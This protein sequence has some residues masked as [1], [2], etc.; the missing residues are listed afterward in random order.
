MKRVLLLVVTSAAALAAGS[1][2][3]AQTLPAMDSV[4]LASDV[5][6]GDEGRVDE[7]G[8]VEERPALSPRA[9]AQM[10]LSQGFS[11]LSP[12]IRRG[13]AYV[14]AVI[15]PNGDDGRVTVDASS[16]RIVR[17]RPIYG[18]GAMVLPDDVRGAFAR[19]DFTPPRN[20]PYV[21]PR[22]APKAASNGAV[23]NGAPKIASKGSASAVSPQKPVTPTEPA[24]K[25]AA[26]AAPA[27]AAPE[28]SPPAAAPAKPVVELQATQPIP[29]VQGFE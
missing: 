25:T 13:P 20:I 18:P 8:L 11:P 22:P 16:G 1:A 24:Q 5:V 27:A 7:N 12:P 6:R 26:V 23:N 14:V 10:L 2:A 29:P 19:R 4:I 3:K 28:K 15:D 9:I 17:F 21:P